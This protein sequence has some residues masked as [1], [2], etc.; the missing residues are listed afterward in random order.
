MATKRR[1]GKSRTSLSAQ[2]LDRFALGSLGTTTMSPR[3]EPRTNLPKPSVSSS[4]RHTSGPGVIY[5]D[6]RL[7][8]E[9][10]QGLPE[11]DW[12]EIFGVGLFL[13]SLCLLPD[14]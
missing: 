3:H 13:A 9:P 6:P 1:R 5:R 11:W 14:A 12:L 10:P 7:S 4:P 8:S 2:D